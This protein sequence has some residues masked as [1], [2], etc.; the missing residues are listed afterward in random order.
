MNAVVDQSGRLVVS[1]GGSGIVATQPVVTTLFLP[2]GTVGTAY[3]VTLAAASGVPPYTW[4]SLGTPSGLTL[5]PAGVLSGTPTTAAVSTITVTATDATSV[6][7]AAVALTL[8][9]NIAQTAT[10][11]VTPAL[12]DAYVGAFWASTLNALG[13]TFPYTW[14]V[15]GVPAWMTL[16]AGGNLSGTPPATG[17]IV[18]GVTATDSASNVSAT[19]NVEINV[20]PAG[21]KWFGAMLPILPQQFS[22]TCSPPAPAATNRGSYYTPGV[23]ADSA[24][25][26]QTA[27][28]NAAAATGSLGDV[29]VVQSG[30]T[31][32]AAVSF[33]L[34]TR[35]GSGWIYVI[36]SKIPEIGGTGL[37]A[38]GT[39]VTRA[40]IPNMAALASSATAN[41]SAY[42]LTRNVGVAGC[43]QYRMVGLDME[44][45]SAANASYVVG[46]GGS[47]DTS[48][49]TL[50][51]NITFD[52]CYVAGSVVNG[53]NTGIQM[54]G[55]NIEVTECR[56]ERCWQ[57]GNADVHA[58]AASNSIGP[59]KIHNNYL[60]SGGEVTFFG[61]GPCLLGGPN[62][63]ADLTITN[64]HYYK[65]SFVGVGD[66]TNTST[67]LNITS[68]TQGELYPVMQVTDSAGALTG[69]VRVV[70]QLTGTAWGVG[71]YQLSAAAGVNAATGLT[72]TAMQ[73]LDKNMVEHKMVRRVLFDSNFLENAGTLG[74]QT[75]AG[76]VMTSVNQNNT[77]W[78][79]LGDFTI[80]NN[81]FTNV[82]NGGMQWKLGD[83]TASGGGPS[84]PG[85]RFLMRNNIFILSRSGGAGP[86]DT[87]QAIG[88]INSNLPPSGSGNGFGGHLIFDHNTFVGPVTTAIHSIIWMGATTASVGQLNNIVWS[89]NIWD[90]S[91]YGIVRGGSA[92]YNW[93]TAVVSQVSQ[94]VCVNNVMTNFSDSALTAT[95]FFPANS[96]AVGYTSYGS[97][98]SALGYALTTGSTYHAKGV[99]GFGVAYNGTGTLD[100]TDIGCNISL[101]PT[102]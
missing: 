76:W 10:V 99:S 61:G 74:N 15:T 32:T 60:N 59:Y 9:V 102:S 88:N 17:V 35:S 96:A 101:L 14:S 85:F 37:P 83:S 6:A 19:I 30:Q 11:V 47:S 4:T 89:N 65:S 71:T 48:I 52:R 68:V 56:I 40:D 7:S 41:P 44:L 100:G 13:G 31:Y 51:Q 80:T 86:P 66:L 58:C 3:S 21:Q 97:I 82:Y 78:S 46:I 53:A 1:A 77:P 26:L 8:V 45:S 39:R 79:V 24:M 55:I 16:D 33:V 34:P 28:N 91:W 75:R 84:N 36:A 67:T 98:T 20:G 54:D 50:A 93:T 12:Q 73:T 64:N 23:G 90:P 5:S 81:V 42:I 43:S 27:L 18:L 95:N 57:S 92:G 87:G 94:A 63:P 72:I 69:T 70:Q 22:T 29:I 25:T 2:T 62:Q 38:A 49:G